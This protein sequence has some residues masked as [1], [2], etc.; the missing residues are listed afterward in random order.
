MRTPR[1]RT[2]VRSDRTRQLISA[3]SLTKSFTTYF[4]RF[5]QWTNSVSAHGL[6]ATFTA[7]FPNSVAQSVR[8]RPIFR[9]NLSVAGRRDPGQNVTDRRRFP[10]GDLATFPY[11][12]NC[13][14]RR[15][16]DTRYERR[17]DAPDSSQAPV[18]ETVKSPSLCCVQPCSAE[19]IK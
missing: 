14:T 2:H 16:S 9:T 7:S 4:Q 1:A 5:G 8:G 19:A 12:T 3:Y 6:P 17:L 15:C 11:K 10:S 13:S 18:L